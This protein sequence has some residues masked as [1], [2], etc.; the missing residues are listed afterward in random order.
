[1]EITQMTIDEVEARLK[2]IEGLVDDESA[3]LDALTDETRA[4][5]ARREELRAAAEKKAEIRAAVA[6]GAGETIKKFEEVRTMENKTYNASSPEYRMAWL[7]R[8]SE[9]DGVSRFGALTEE[10]RTAYTHTTANTGAVVP[11]AVLNAIEDLVDSEAPI[12]DD[13]VQYHMTQ[14]FQLPRFTAIAAGDAAG[15]AEGAAPA[16]DEQDT[17]GYLP[18]AGV[19][20]KKCAVLSRKMQFQSI[21]AFQDWLVQEVGKRI[22]VE[23]ERM[24]LARMSG[25]QYPSG[26]TAVS[27]AAIESTYHVITGSGTTY[28]D[29]TDANIRSYLGLIHGAGE[30]VIY[31]NRKTIYTGLMGIVDAEKRQM[32]LPNSMSDPLVAGYLYGAKVKVDPNLSDNVVYFIRKGALVCNDFSGTELFQALEPRTANTI[33]TGYALF[34]GGMVDQSGAVK[35]TFNPTPAG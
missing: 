18:L 4:L 22:R 26:V 32:F 24:L 28:V 10:E 14:G 27:G 5:K 17:I 11:T 21:E 6:S 1:M 2:E 13:A 23:K 29:Y 12:Y 31:A 35:V 34:D 20:I 16:N 15:T 19:E 25:S 30:V 3:D 9:I 8:M 7:K 33:I